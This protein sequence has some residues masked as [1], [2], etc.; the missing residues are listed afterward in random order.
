M[1]NNNIISSRKKKKLIIIASCSIAVLLIFL[2]A[3]HAVV[4]NG[5]IR[6]DAGEKRELNRV[7]ILDGIAEDTARHEVTIDASNACV[8]DVCVQ[9]AT[10]KS[11]TDHGQV[12]YTLYNRGSS[13]KTGYLILV[14]G[15]YKALIAYDNLDAGATVTS[16][17]AY[18]GFNLQSVSNYSVTSASE[19]DQRFVVNE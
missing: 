3:I 15:N 1:Q 10:I 7:S 11:Y 17:Y 14:L 18:D 12:D 8:D 19:V 4:E 9:S 5:K 16:M 2:F 6:S 13:T